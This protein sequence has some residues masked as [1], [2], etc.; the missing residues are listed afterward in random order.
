M[1]PVTDFLARRAELSPSAIALTDPA[2]ERR[3]SY[4]EWN[5]RVNRT[6]HFLESLGVGVG[7]RVAVYSTNRVEYLDLIF[8]VSKLG[9]ATLNLNWRLTP[10][11]LGEF[12][13]NGDPAV[14]V[15]SDE[16][17]DTVDALD[18]GPGVAV[19]ALGDPRQGEHGF[20]ERHGFPDADP[21]PLELGLDHMWGIYPTGGTTGTPKGAVLSHGNITWNAIN[22]VTSWGLHAGH[23][24][25]VQLPMF[26]IGGPNIF[27]IPLVYVGGTTVVCSDF[28]PGETLELIDSGR[29]THYVGVPTMYQ[30]LIDHPDFDSTDFSQMELV[31]SGGAPCP[32]PI[33][34]R[35]W[36]RG[37]DFKVGY[38][39]T[40]ASGNNFWLPPEQVRDKPGS[41][42]YPLLHIRA[43]IVGDSGESC[44]ANEPGELQL[45]GPHVFSGYWR[46][47][48]A[49]AETLEDGWLRT[50]DVAVR[51]DDGAYRVIGRSKEMFISGGEN[52]Y[53]AEV[54]SV[55]AAHPAVVEAAVVAVPDRKWG[56]VGA[57]FIAPR[58]GASIDEVELLDFCRERLASF[59]L[60]K[61]VRF[62]PELPKT[63]IGKHDKKAMAASIAEGGSST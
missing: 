54:E 30:L 13:R 57:A 46:R 44:P 12:V 23:V 2:G 6:A 36:D 53:P 33:M 19:V 31:I 7:D 22:T 10:S 17:V 35:F 49:T 40:E 5:R 58:E 16:W 3:T 8:A 52:V 59:K 51:D 39:L 43:R 29:I 4:G 42:G 41:V 48:D 21:A 56:E 61:H 14:L 34:Q 45:A 18:L 15:Y 20:D 26:H 38:G 9:A 60:P 55:I 50:G 32:L 28:D 27:V 25:P 63:A 1:T 37:V 47:P 62:L 24:A 11:E